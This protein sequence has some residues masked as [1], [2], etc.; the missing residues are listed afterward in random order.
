MNKSFLATPEDVFAQI[1]PII[2]NL[3]VMAEAASA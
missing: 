1:M 2:Q 3:D